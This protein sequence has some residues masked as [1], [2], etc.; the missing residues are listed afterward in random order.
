[1]TVQL[2]RIDALPSRDANETL[3]LA[4]GLPLPPLLEPRMAFDGY[5]IVRELHGSN[6]SHIYLAADNETLETVVIKTP[7]VDLQDDPH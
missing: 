4:S 5:T 3:R 1:M 2:V 7:S 6:R